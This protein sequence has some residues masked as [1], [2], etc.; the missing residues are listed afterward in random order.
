MVKS[1]ITSYRVRTVRGQQR[2]QV[3]RYFTDLDI[4]D[5]DEVDRLRKRFM[6]LDKVQYHHS[7]ITFNCHC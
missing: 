3:C 5:R 4:V 1:L 7:V 2:K 6:K